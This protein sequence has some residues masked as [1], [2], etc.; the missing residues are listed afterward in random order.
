MTYKTL[1]SVYGVD[2]H[3]FFG[4]F[5]F[6]KLP[7]TLNTHTR[8]HELIGVSIVQVAHRQWGPPWGPSSGPTPHPQ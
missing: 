4:L 8:M 5:F 2:G 1:H 3:F 7:I 6:E